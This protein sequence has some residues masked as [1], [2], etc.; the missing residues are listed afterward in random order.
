MDVAGIGIDLALLTFN[1]ALLLD[2]YQQVHLD[3]QIKNGTEVDGINLDGA[4]GLWIPKD[5]YIYNR[6]LTKSLFRTTSWN[7]V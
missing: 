4:F 7:S 3:L 2:A 5:L 6:C 1:V